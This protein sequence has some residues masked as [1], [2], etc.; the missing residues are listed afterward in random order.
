MSKFRI[1]AA[2]DIPRFQ[3]EGIDVNQSWSEIDTAKLEPNTRDALELYTGSHVQVYP[4]DR[5]TFASALG[6]EWGDDG[7]LRIP[8]ADPKDPNA[9]KLGER[10][11][12]KATAKT[13]KAPAAST[14]KADTTAGATTE[15]AT[16]ET[17]DTAKRRNR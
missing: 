14:T 2:G 1:K 12:A 15:P 5:D 9:P 3:H 17:T 16:E 11:T 7:R 8:G 10:H 6:L 4:D 13:A